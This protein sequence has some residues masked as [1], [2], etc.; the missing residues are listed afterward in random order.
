MQGFSP[1]EDG[2]M[3]QKDESVRCQ[4]IK[5]FHAIIKEQQ[6]Q[7][8]GTGAEYIVHWWPGDEDGNGESSEPA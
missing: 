5:Q 4:L 1:I 3:C 6:V 7:G 2:M 8:V